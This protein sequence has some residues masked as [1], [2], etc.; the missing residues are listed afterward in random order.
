[1][2]TDR[3]LPWYVFGVF[4]VLTLLAT[5]YVW[6]ST[7]AADRARFDNA[8]QT[9]GDAIAA[10][11]DT[12]IN[13][14]NA[15][16]GLVASDPALPRKRLRDYIRSHEVQRR[17][18][19]IQGIGFSL[20]V[21]AEH[22]KTLEEEMR[23]EGFEDFRVWPERGGAAGVERHSIVVLEPSDRRNAAAM[24]FDMSTNPGLRAAM[25]R[26]RDTGEPTASGH[27]T[28]VQEID[29]AKQA[30]FLIY[31]PVYTTGFAPRTIAERRDTL[32]GFVYAPFR[33]GDLLDRIFGSQERPEIGFQIT[34]A[35][36]TLFRTANLP[37]N[38]RW[39]ARGELKVAGR[40]WDVL[41]ISRREGNGPA[42]ML[43][44]AT[45]FG[46]LI[47]AS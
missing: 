8:V 20:R 25:N 34:D 10:R 33:A 11:L 47:I 7:R 3:A 38:P 36:R 19:G 29:P 9:T 14:L 24:G 18:P 15:T 37:S 44:A 27:V 45:L 32:V 26:A 39:T 16:R 12:Y 42:V 1:M 35:G 31:T 4:V 43:A 46:G 13:L 41:W 5:S 22:V 21:P 28:L 40:K 30:G 23:R 2:T 6:R 17:Y